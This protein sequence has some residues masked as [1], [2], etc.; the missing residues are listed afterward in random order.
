MFDSIIATIQAVAKGLWDALIRNGVVVWG[1]IASMIGVVIAAV[2]TLS[3]WIAD[4]GS[5]LANVVLPSIGFTVPSEVTDLLGF[6]NRIMPLT[7]LMGYL[8]AWGALCAV[9]MVYHTI[10]S[11][12]PTVSGS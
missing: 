6:V 11:W 3:G 1:I 2:N 12:L 5:T 8:I 9:L 4:A 10:K 7:E